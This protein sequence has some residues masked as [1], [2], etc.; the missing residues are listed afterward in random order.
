VTSYL[1]S[2]TDTSD[3]GTGAFGPEAGNVTVVAGGNVTGHY[4]V[5]NGTGRIIA[6]AKMDASGQPAGRGG[7]PR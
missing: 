6:G 4:V 7:P 3:A 5:A 2:Q 1:P